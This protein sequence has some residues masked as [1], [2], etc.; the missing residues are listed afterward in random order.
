[1]ERDPV[2]EQKQGMFY[3]QISHWLK[4]NDMKT[5][6]FDDNIQVILTCQKHQSES[7]MMKMIKKC[8]LVNRNN[9]NDGNGT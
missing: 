7:E 9:N 2:S 4:L 8:E 1:M 5:I 6:L 3:S